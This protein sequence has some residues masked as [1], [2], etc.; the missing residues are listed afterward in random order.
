MAAQG[1]L[2]QNTTFGPFSWFSP[3]PVVDLLTSDTWDQKQAKINAAPSRVKLRF[4]IG[5]H[6]YDVGSTTEILTIPQQDVIVTPGYVDSTTSAMF[7]LLQNYQTLSNGSWTS[8]ATLNITGT[9]KYANIWVA[10][11]PSI[12][13][14]AWYCSLQSD[15][16]TY[17]GTTYG[18]S[19]TPLVWLGASVTG[20]GTYGTVTLET[21][22][23]NAT[24]PTGFIV[25]DGG[26]YGY[27][28]NSIIVGGFGAGKDPTNGSVTVSYVPMKAPYLGNFYGCIWFQP[29][30]EY[31]LIDSIAF[32]GW[33]AYPSQNGGDGVYG[34]GTVFFD[35]QVWGEARNCDIQ[36][37]GTII[38]VNLGSQGTPY[39][40]AVT[41]LGGDGF[42]W[43]E[44]A[45]GVASNCSVVGA[46]N[47][48]F[49]FNG[50]PLTTSSQ[51]Q[52]SVV[53]CYGRRFG[54]PPAMLNTAGVA[55]TA[56]AVSSH[57]NVS[58]EIR[59]CQL[60]ESAAPIIAHAGAGHSTVIDC[61]LAGSLL[62]RGWTGGVNPNAGGICATNGNGT[63]VNNCYPT[64]KI[65]STTISNCQIGLING[66]PN[67]ITAFNVGTGT[68]APYNN[69][70]ADTG[71]I[72]VLNPTTVQP[73]TF[74]RQTFSGSGTISAAGGAIVASNGKSGAQT[75][76]LPSAASGT[77][78]APIYLIIKDED[79]T[80]ATNN[81]TVS[82][83]GSDTIDG[84]TTKT[85]NTNFGVLRLEGFGTTWFSV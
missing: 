62:A 53:S 21:A 84:A 55:S 57:N 33:S 65:R 11:R 18:G 31:A 78:S 80:A 29:T 39:D 17:G 85:I 77:S 43:Y 5:T 6:T 67:P 61:T 73:T 19:D 71:T 56:N 47:D 30:C 35:R 66:G 36:C 4:Q 32:K 44:C 70:N 34:Q 38:S 59:Q 25:R 42:S 69:L 16:A 12:Y 50:A 8:S 14:A 23:H 76:T 10:A 63:T 49:H 60:Y 20:S 75:L 83:A 81:I 15:G 26:A 79:G 3:R 7:P 64:F 41:G 28:Q 48:G 40:A 51:C 54:P 45:Q 22:V 13:F 82:R 46:I 58:S 27:A 74:G 68:A 24:V 2:N 72:T 37:V 52:W 9:G 1:I